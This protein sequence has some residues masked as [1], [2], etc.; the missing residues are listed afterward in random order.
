MIVSFSLRPR[1]S[2]VRAEHLLA[3]EVVYGLLQLIVR[4]RLR[5]VRSNRQAVDG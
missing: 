3:N 1:E 2:A 4:R 5:Q